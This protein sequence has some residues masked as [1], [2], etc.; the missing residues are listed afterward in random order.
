MKDSEFEQKELRNVQMSELRSKNEELIQK[1]QTVEQ[2]LN[3]ASSTYEAQ[4]KELENQMGVN[5]AKD[6]ELNNLKLVMG[7]LEAKLQ[8][9]EQQ[10]IDMGLE[11]QASVKALELKLIDEGALQVELKGANENLISQLEAANL[12]FNSMNVAFEQQLEET[13][14]QLK[15]LQ[16]TLG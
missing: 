7:E 11:Y 6:A 15:Q 16:Q 9:A 13:K 14:L 8:A 3:D 12:Q 10:S 2:Q 4:Q 5:N 1:L